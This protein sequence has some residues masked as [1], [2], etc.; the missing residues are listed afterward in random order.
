MTVWDVGGRDKIRPLYRHYFQNTNII[1]FVIDSNDKERLQE[2]QEEMFKMLSEDELRECTVLILANKQDLHNALSVEEI[3]S[4]IKFDEIKQ[5]KKNI[6]GTDAISGVGINDAFNWTTEN[7]F[8]K[9]LNETSKD[10]KEMFL[11]F[12]CWFSK[13]LKTQIYGLEKK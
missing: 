6:F 3:K 8:S 5:V 9:P 12:S 1:V 11:N 2:A 7:L 13:I 4:K 10:F